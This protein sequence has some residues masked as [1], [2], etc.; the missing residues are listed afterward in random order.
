MS[1]GDLP[2][3]HGVPSAVET[4]RIGFAHSKINRVSTLNLVI[5]PPQLCGYG[6]HRL[7]RPIG[8]AAILMMHSIT[9]SAWKQHGKGFLIVNWGI[10]LI[11]DSSHRRK[12]LSWKRTRA[13]LRARALSASLVPSTLRY[14]GPVCPSTVASTYEILDVAERWQPK[15]GCLEALLVFPLK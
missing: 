5:E 7:P 9:W 12:L 2:E 15:E 14:A 6:S 13:F 3:G 11:V 4:V 1:P 8:S 10:S